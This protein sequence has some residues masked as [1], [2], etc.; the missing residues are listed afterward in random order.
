M[1][2]V[3]CVEQMHRGAVTLHARFER[4][5]EANRHSRSFTTCRCRHDRA[6]GN[7]NV[8]PDRTIRPLSRRRELQCLKPI[9]QGLS[10]HQIEGRLR[11]P[12]RADRLNLRIACRKLEFSKLD[13]SGSRQ[14]N[15]ARSD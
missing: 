6:M 13:R 11:I 1:P 15:A 4:Q 8:R 7:S 10:S 12:E 14:R 2:R 5:D 3:R 9:A